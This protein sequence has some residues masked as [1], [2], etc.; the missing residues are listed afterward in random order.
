MDVVIEDNHHVLKILC[1]W[2]TYS[3]KAEEMFTKEGANVTFVNKLHPKF[4]AIDKALESV[5]ENFEDSSQG[6][7]DILLPS[8]IQMDPAS[9]KYYN[10]TKTDGTNLLFF[11][12][13]CVRSDYN[14][15]KAEKSIVFV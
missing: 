12:F 9:W 5:R 3:Y 1:N 14:I 7:I 4:L 6:T 11:E 8:T 10:N 13:L 2:P 15:K